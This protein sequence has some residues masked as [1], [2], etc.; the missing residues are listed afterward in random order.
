MQ[1]ANLIFFISDNHRRDMVGAYGHPVVQT[2]ALDKL[3]ARGTRFTN[4]YSASAVCCPARASLATGRYA[5]QTG[6]WDNAIVYDGRV[7]SWHHRLREQGHTVTSVGKLHF[8]SSEDD[9]G[10]TEEIIPMHIVEGKGALFGLLRATPEG[11]RP[12]RSPAK[13]Y[14]D[15]AVGEAD[16]LDYD[17]D[18]S[19]HAIAWL[20]AN[21]RKVGKP[22]VLWV[23]YTTPHPPF[24]VPRELMDLYPP[25]RMP[26]PPLFAEADQPRHPAVAHLRKTMGYEGLATEAFVR[27]VFAG[28]C[29]LTT[30]MDS[31]VGRVMAAVEEMGLLDSTR[32]LYTSDHG[33]AA[34]S[35]GLFGKCGLY[36]H[37]IGVPLIMSG[38]GIP[39]QRTIREIVSHVDLF[40]TVL[41]SAGAQLTPTDA[42]LK[43]TSLW[44]A[45]G[46]FERQRLGFCEYHAHA[47]KNGIT[48]LRDG[49]LKLIYNVGLPPQVF[50]LAQD[51]QETRD[52]SQAE[53]GALARKLEAKLRTLV[54]PEAVDQQ[55]KLDQAA[56]VEEE[57][58]REAILGR[59]SFA[60]NPVPGKTAELL[61]F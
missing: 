4:A 21:A 6:Y 16:Y 5:H 46:G 45:I 50:D 53:G 60:H 11:E 30:F 1:P 10:F 47:S 57:G 61:R 19:A 58:G 12:R 44:P 54:D 26:L 22:W 27:K 34:G 17:R 28:Y 14:E 55:A 39:A 48:M 31:Q 20:K 52:L 59:G 24:V 51:P 2:P 43:G 7:P 33:E 8:R 49:D 15:T 3:A 40:P 23:S 41:E 32:M 56:R 38:P 13:T 18:I 42:D 37:S 29:A 25:E 35:H 9:N 36:E